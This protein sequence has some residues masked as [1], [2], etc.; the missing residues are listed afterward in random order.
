MNEHLQTKSFLTELCWHLL[1][2]HLE[3][4]KDSL[5]QRQIYRKKKLFRPIFL[6]QEASFCF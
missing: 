5:H 1:I 4:M 2:C 6:D 3:T